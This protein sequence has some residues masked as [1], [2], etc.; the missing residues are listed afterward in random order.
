MD[1]DLRQYQREMALSA[2]AG[3]YTPKKLAPLTTKPINR[4]SKPLFD[5]DADDEDDDGAIHQAMEQ[6][7][8]EED[9]ELAFAIQESL[10]HAKS[11]AQ[12]TSSR[13]SPTKAPSSELLKESPRS[14]GFPNA[15]RPSPEVDIFTPS[16][17]ET[18]LA[19]AGTGP[20]RRI[21]GRNISESQEKNKSSFG[22]PSL[23]SSSRSHPTSSN[24]TPKINGINENALRSEAIPPSEELPPLSTTP[25]STIPGFRALTDSEEDDD[26]E[27]VDVPA[28][29]PVVETETEIQPTDEQDK[30]SISPLKPPHDQIESEDNDMEEVEVVILKPIPTEKLAMSPRLSSESSLP[31]NPLSRP[32]P[33]AQP[34]ALAPTVVA[35]ISDTPTFSPPSTPDKRTE[36]PLFAWSRSPSPSR[37]REASAG[38]GEAS[39]IAIP[40]IDV[41]SYQ[42]DHEGDLGNAENENVE[43]EHWD[44]AHEMDPHA[45]EGEFARFLSQVKGRDLDDV[46]KEIDDEIK[47]LNEQ[48]KAAMRDSED[49]TQQMISQIMVSRS[50]YLAWAVHLT[51]CCRQ[52]CGYSAYLI[53][54]RRWKPRPNAQ[55]SFP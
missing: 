25:P 14:V 20:S 38:L 24:T 35:N 26:M 30:T 23:L 8:D 33:E 29:V 40:T 3:R 34:Q 49:I 10:D 7:E 21:L 50:N 11:T 2:I 28:S 46:R 6:I 41:A 27:E 17:L 55:N 51:T 31:K 47:V 16:G 19:F 37:N 42:P 12:Q 18:A 43:E 32:E 5:L 54:P 45:E 1:P 9:E 53:S 22:I 13:A 36:T 4:N 39:A 52:C 48:R 15:R 44:A